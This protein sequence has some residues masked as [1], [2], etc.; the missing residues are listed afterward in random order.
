MWSFG[1]LGYAKKYQKVE[2]YGKYSPP[3][4]LAWV[5]GKQRNPT[6]RVWFRISPEPYEAI[7]ENILSASIVCC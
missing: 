4:Q 5:G 3:F 2:E 6:L 7:K 1:A